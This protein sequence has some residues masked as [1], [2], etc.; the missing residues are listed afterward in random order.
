MV[1]KCLYKTLWKEAS[2]SIYGTDLMSLSYT[3]KTY[4]ESKAELYQV[5][6]DSDEIFYRADILTGAAD[7]DRQ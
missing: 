6:Y 3:H 1:T 2:S 5:C 7:T 4:S